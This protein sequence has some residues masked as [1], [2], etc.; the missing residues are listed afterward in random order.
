MPTLLAFRPIRILCD[1]ANP[2]Y[3]REQRTGQPPSIVRGSP[4]VFQIGLALDGAIATGVAALVTSLHL[5]VRA[6]ADP[7]AAP[8]M[9]GSVLTADID[10]DLTQADWTAKSDQH[11]AIEFDA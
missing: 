3:V 11:A 10:D 5:Q 4:T 2:N 6:S 7:S 8:L 1:L 9:D